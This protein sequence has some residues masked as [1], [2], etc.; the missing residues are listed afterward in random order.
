MMIDY[1]IVYQNSSVYAHLFDNNLVELI[2]IGVNV[3]G[4][5]N[6]EIFN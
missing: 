4:L 2:N 1:I 5:F 3:A 6:S